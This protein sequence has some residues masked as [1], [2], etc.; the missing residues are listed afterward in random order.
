MRPTPMRDVISIEQR[1]KSGA[2]FDQ[3]GVE[4]CAAAAGPTAAIG[5][6]AA[7]ATPAR[8]TRRDSPS[9]G[10]RDS[11][12]RHS[13]PRCPIA[14]CRENESTESARGGN[15]GLSMVMVVCSLI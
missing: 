5:R 13:F 8:T 11:L 12:R 4:A 14:G 9:A 1:L 15:I 10:L 7:E 2:E 6:A 3:F